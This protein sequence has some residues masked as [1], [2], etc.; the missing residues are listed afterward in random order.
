MINIGILGFGTVGSGVV[1][2]LQ[3]NYELISKKISAQIKVA[4][5]ADL[6]IETDRGIEVDRSILTKDG[7]ALCSNPDIDIIVEL[8]GGTGV[9]AEFIES[10]LKNGKHVITAN[11]ALLSEKGSELFEMAEKQDKLLLFEAAVGGAIPI[12]RAIKTSFAGENI[13]KIYGILNGTCNYIL[14]KLA[15]GRVEFADV[16]KEA[17]DKGFAEADPTLDIEGIDAAHKIALLAM[18]NWGT[19]VDFKKVYVEGIT[20]LI[21]HDFDFA[22][23]LKRVIKL[24]AVAKKENGELELRVHPTLLPEDSA[25]AKVDGVVNAVSV[26]GPNLGEC[27][28]S[29]FGAGSL[30]TATAVVGDIVEAAKAI[31]SKNFCAPIRGVSPDAVTEIPVKKIEDVVSEYYLRID[32]DERPGVIRDVATALA[33]H[34]LSIKDILQLDILDFE[35]PV[36]IVIILQPA[37]EAT[38]REAVKE[39]ESLDC[40]SGKAVVIRVEE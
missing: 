3:E 38:V 4:A 22:K 19:K 27:L 32:V 24:V 5:I 29:G 21:S 8:V 37:K 23:R 28:L 10:A 9:A 13:E 25:L 12:V 18:L 20:N 17:Q 1:K 11:K 6:D 30:P 14:T 35:K 26:C 2:I 31:V 34:D 33:N 16:L 15:K 40:T 7:L 36:P 39:I